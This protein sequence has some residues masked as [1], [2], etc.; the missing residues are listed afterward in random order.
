MLI[1]RID[2]QEVRKKFSP[3]Q[4]S[5]LA[6]GSSDGAESRPAREWGCLP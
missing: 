6:R 4:S 2:L 5:A 3:S 1:D